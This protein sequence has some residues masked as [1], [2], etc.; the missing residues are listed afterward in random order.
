M[1]VLAATD[2]DADE[3]G[4]VQTKSSGKHGQVCGRWFIL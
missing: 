4:A 2:T 3:E 1:Q